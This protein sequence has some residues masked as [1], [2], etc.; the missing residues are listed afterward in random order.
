MNK[1]IN[2]DYN[3][4]L[5]LAV[6]ITLRAVAQTDWKSPRSINKQALRMPRLGKITTRYEKLADITTAHLT[7]SHDEIKLIENVEM[8]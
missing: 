8:R 6:L 1:E 5:R 4:R 2:M 7:F 3:E